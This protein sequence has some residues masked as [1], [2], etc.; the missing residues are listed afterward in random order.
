MDV[1]SIC[2]LA[3]TES[4]LVDLLIK[5]AIGGLIGWVASL[6]MKSDGQMGIIAN[7]VVGI[8]GSALGHFLAGALGISFGGQIGGILSALGGAVLLI[9]IL[10]AL[11]IMK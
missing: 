11:T 1:S 6:V 10:R 4:G 7:I 8:V 2:V 3:A 9:V 5:L